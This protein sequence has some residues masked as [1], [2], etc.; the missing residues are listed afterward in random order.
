MTNI[1]RIGLTWISFLSY[2]FTG[3]L[4]VVTGMIMGNISNYFHLSIS[5]MSNIFTFLNAGILVSIFINSWLIEIISLKKQLIFSFILTIIAVIGIVLCNSIFL[6]SINMFILGLVSGI[7]M[8]IGTFIITHLYS[9]SKRGSLLLLTD[10][11]FSM[12]GMIFPIVTAYLLEKKIIWYWSYICIGAIYLLIFLLTINSSFEKFKTNTKNSKETK[13][14]WNFNVFLL[15]ISALLYILGQLGFISWVPQYATEIMNIDI[16]KTGS[17][18]SGFWMS[19]MLGMWFF[20]FII[21]FF[22]L[23]RMFIFLTSMSTILMY[24][25][26]KSE[27][28]LNQQYI[29]ISLGFFSSAIYTIIITLASLQTK[30][31]SPKLI[32]L[33]LLFGTIGTFLT[34]II[35]S[36]I[37]EAKGLYVTLISSN[38]L[39]GIVFFLSILIYFNKKYERVI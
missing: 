7:T 2:A 32:N 9:G 30:H 26:I 21:K 14:K 10:S 3:A 23:Y 33:I 4:V 17:L 29:I 8:S 5:Q 6:F 28:F 27:N 13:E 25:F 15:S 34:F 38:I 36:P 18:V 16:K 24:C 37:V 22:N 35:T 11:F 20:S 12:S 1:N 31:P 19:Y 39:Y